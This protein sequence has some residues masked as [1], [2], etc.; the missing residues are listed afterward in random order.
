MQRCT[1]G[2]VVL[3]LLAGAGCAGGGEAALET[4]EDSAA[5]AVGVNL[6]LGLRRQVPDIRRDQFLRGVGD[7]LD[8]RALAI[9]DTT[10]Q[11]LLQRYAQQATAA[12]DERAQREGQMHAESGRQFLEENAQRPGVQTTA[13]GLQYEVVQEGS[14]PKPRATDTVS[15]HYRGTLIDGTE[16]DASDRAG[17]PVTFPLN[18]VIPGW[19][20][21]VQL[22][23]VGS[24]YK[25]YLPAELGYG[26]RG[27]PPDIPPNATLIFEVE[28]VDIQ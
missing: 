2:L 7:A 19:T 14:G 13:S 23:S 11:T 10:L 17:D 12:A 15:V 21:G 16:F 27:A 20:E 5:Y 3:V 25:L 26:A 6:G 22:M 9:D 1:G 28:L 4:F 8:E 24:V 18:R